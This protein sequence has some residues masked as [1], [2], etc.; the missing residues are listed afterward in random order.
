[1]EFRGG[2]GAGD[3]NMVDPGQ[4]MLLGQKPAKESEQEW[5]VRGGEEEKAQTPGE[6]SSGRGRNNQLGHRK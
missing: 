3:G 4:A 5:L 6:M 2:L 1:M